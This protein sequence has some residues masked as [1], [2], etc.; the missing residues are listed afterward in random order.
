LQRDLAGIF[1]RLHLPVVAE[2][3]RRGLAV[4]TYIRA[5]EI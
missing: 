3:H 5:E 4:V 2:G 1:S